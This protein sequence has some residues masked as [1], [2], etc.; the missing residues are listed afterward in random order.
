MSKYEPSIL[1]PCN[2]TLFRKAL[3]Y[4]W[5]RAA[6][7]GESDGLPYTKRSRG[8]GLSESDELDQFG[9]DHTTKLSANRPPF[10]SVLIYHWQQGMEEMRGGA[11]E[12]VF[13]S[14]FTYLDQLSGRLVAGHIFTSSPADVCL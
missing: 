1:H 4:I 5:H 8:N 14:D 11:G 12:G 2:I 3:V 9:T 13:S 10:P 6:G 7:A